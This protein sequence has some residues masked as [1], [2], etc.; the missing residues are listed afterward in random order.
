MNSTARATVNDY[1][2]A[3]WAHCS[4]SEIIEFILERFHEPLHRE[5]P[6]LV[7]SAREVEAETRAESQC[8]VGIGDHLEQVLL[9][10]ESHLA[11]EEKLL[12][13]LIMSGRG[14]AA[15]MPIKAMMAEH[16]DHA[17]NLAHTRALTHDFTLPAHASP[18]W[19]GLYQNL[20]RLESELHQHIALENQV[21]F[22]RVMGDDG[23]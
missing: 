1:N 16:E 7:A 22:T 10:V 13:P 3:R 5:L 9:A 17:A 21:L 15:F 20:E 19:R 6:A 11:K 23:I 4:P 14:H 18:A 2:E 12:F 8:P